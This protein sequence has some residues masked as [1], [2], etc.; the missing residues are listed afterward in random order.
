MAR[1]LTATDDEILA[2]AAEEFTHNGA[3]GFSLS[4][5]ARQLGLSR[6]AITARFKSAEDLKR[7]IARQK[8]EIY[9]RRFA[10]L[11]PERS[12]AGLL[13]VVEEVGA[14]LSTASNFAGFLSRYSNN[15]DDPIWGE[16][17][18]RRGDI[19]RSVI[20][21]A[22]PDTV[23]TREAAADQFMALI[24]GS[25]MSWHS[26]DNEAPATYLRRRAL[27]WAQLAGLELPPELQ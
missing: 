11:K 12:V 7:Q 6:A 2:V 9:E 1:P 5:V 14:M 8:L 26:E 20:I 22:M 13:R 10:S 23:L 24:A 4:R 27:Q 21:E 16:M 15:I 19:L 17:E 25:I 18:R 3:S